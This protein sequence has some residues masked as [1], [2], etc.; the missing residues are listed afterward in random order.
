MNDPRNL[1]L[2]AKAVELGGVRAAARV[3]SVPKTTISR[4]IAQLETKLGAQL[5]ERSPRKITLTELG[6]MF[7]QHCRRVVQDIEEAEAAVGTMQGVARGRL[8][9]AAP[10]T[11]GR[12]LLSPVLAEFLQAYPEIR[13]ELE[14]TNRKVDPAEEG[15]DF[16]IRLGPL[17]DSSL[18]AKDLGAL[19]FALCASPRYL[20]RGLT[21]THPRDLAQH[22][23]IDFFG[24]ADHRVWTFLKGS[25]SVN[26]EVTPRLDANDPMVRRDAAV[27]GLGI[28]LLPIW[29]FNAEAP[30]KRLIRLLP[31]WHSA[32][33]TRIYALYPSRRSLT[34]KSRAFLSFLQAEIPAK[35]G[36]STSAKAA[37]VP[38]RSV[39]A[40]HHHE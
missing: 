39:S 8:R 15:F 10:V 32:V 1:V 20:K 29:L 23:V 3:L 26:V 36:T 5:L 17:D 25:D 27:A 40:G 28:A 21:L 9:V 11:F 6:Q 4:A 12:S 35:L 37:G 7:F 2:F 16:V 30:A 33:S 18:I 13:M 22:K 34:P 31:G 14:L 19:T 38:A 24:G